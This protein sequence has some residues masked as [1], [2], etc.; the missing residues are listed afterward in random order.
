[1]KYKLYGYMHDRDD[2]CR[3]IYRKRPELENKEQIKE[4]IEELKEICN[5]NPRYEYEYKI[6]K[7]LFQEVNGMKELWEVEWESKSRDGMEIIGGLI[8][9]DTLEELET[10]METYK[11][12]SILGK[13]F[14]KPTEF[15][16]IIKKKYE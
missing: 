16:E 5:K 12:R 15:G 9:K 8:K 3:T 2:C 6:I 10:S 14:I 13:I 11:N 7:K 1:M 4:E